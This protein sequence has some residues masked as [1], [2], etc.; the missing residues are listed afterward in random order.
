M[1]QLYP[2]VGSLFA[3]LV[4]ATCAG[5]T[6]TQITPAA[7]SIDGSG[8]PVYEGLID[9]GAAPSTA[10][11]SP[12]PLDAGA[13]VNSELDDGGTQGI[14]GDMGA[15]ETDA[16]KR[17]AQTPECVVDEPR[18]QALSEYWSGDASQYP[19][20]LVHGFMGWDQRWWLDYFFD[21]PNTLDEIG[22]S[23]FVAALD[24]VAGSMVRSQQLLTFV[25]DVRA[26]SCAE[27]V[28]LIGHSQ[29]GL[30]A[31][32]LIGVHNQ[33]DHVESITTISSPHTGF[34]LAD[35]VLA[36]RGLGPA[37]L[38]A[39]TVLTAGLLLGPSMDEANL[40]ATLG[41]MSIETRTAYNQ[42]Y[43]DPPEVPIYSY[44][45][46]TGPL[47][48]GR[49]DCDAGENEAPR[50]GDFVEPALLVL[51]GLLGGRQV[52]N[53]GVVPVSACIWGRFLGCVAADHWDQVGQAA[54]LSDQFNF[55]A[56]YRAHARF[57]S[58]SG[59]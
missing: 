44:A 26:C 18:C 55:R 20:V 2:K 53:D 14:S 19:L 40:R 43:P 41:S 58:D 6:D 17:D 49:P 31:R 24:P 12:P 22:Y 3:W 37:F 28:N 15:I 50:R 9:S 56:F 48:N 36:S 42:A 57:L 4:F 33:A 46:F 16:G 47:S 52:P 32:M 35:D 5:C 13:G 30:D 21:I 59:H 51:Y 8:D 39:L 29:G 34:S 1:M 7:G 38:D 11:V 45:G 27:K 10:D 23:V 25:N 54:G